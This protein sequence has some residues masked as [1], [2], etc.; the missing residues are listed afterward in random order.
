LLLLP[1]RERERELLEI[2]IELSLFLLNFD[3][4]DWTTERPNQTNR[5]K[6]RNTQR[7]EYFDA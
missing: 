5:K 3:D 1:F 7:I 2:G 4:L 6:K